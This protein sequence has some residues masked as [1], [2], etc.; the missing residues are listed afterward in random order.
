MSVRGKGPNCNVKEW[1]TFM[2]GWH[3]SSSFLVEVAGQG[4]KSFFVF[5]FI[6]SSQAENQLVFHLN[7]NPKFSCCNPIKKKKLFI[8]KWLQPNNVHHPVG[9][10]Q[11]VQQE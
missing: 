8:I 6:T 10:W 4:T 7:V 2:L 1:E 11:C 5:F 3:G 9:R